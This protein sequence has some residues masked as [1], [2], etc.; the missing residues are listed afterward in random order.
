MNTGQKLK[1]KSDFDKY[2][3]LVNFETRQWQHCSGDDD[4]NIFWASVWTVKQIFNPDTGQ[5]L[6]DFQLLNHFPNPYELTRKDRLY[7]NIERLQHAKG[8]KHFN[9]VPKTFMIPTEYSEFA[10]T[11]HRMRGAW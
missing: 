11:H 3:I 1:W 7:Q 5:R 9:F 2:V 6:G 4:W 8:T 10:A